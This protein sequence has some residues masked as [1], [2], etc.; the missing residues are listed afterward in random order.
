M[1]DPFTIMAVTSMAATAAGA[2]VAAYGAR[3]AGDAKAGMYRYQA[4]IA[5]YNSRIA[6]QNADYERKAGEIDANISGL[7]T[8]FALG[9]IAAG[10]G[11]SGLDVNTGSPVE[12]RDSQIAIGKR[13]QDQI[14][15][16]S[17]RRAYGYEIEAANKTAQGQLYQMSADESIRASKIDAAKSILGGVSSVSSKWLQGRQAGLFGGGSSSWVGD[18]GYSGWIDNPDA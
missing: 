2:G 16:N 9:N 7:K 8:R 3:Q 11:A 10:Q 18:S 13:D 4:G 12:V 5:D 17:A 15:T 14:R 1:A 6:K